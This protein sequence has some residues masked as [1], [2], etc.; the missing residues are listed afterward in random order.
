MSASDDSQGRPLDYG[1][2]PW[3]GSPEESIGILN[4]GLSPIS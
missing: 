3:F 2:W 4:V 1:V